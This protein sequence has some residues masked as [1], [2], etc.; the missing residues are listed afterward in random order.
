MASDQHNFPYG[1]DMKTKKVNITR[2]TSKTTTVEKCYSI[3]KSPIDDLL[4]VADDSALLGVYFSDCDHVPLEKENWSRNDRH[5]ILSKTAAELAE[6]FTGKRKDFS[7]PLRFDGT[8][9]QRK[10]WKQIAAI[11]YRETIN[12]SE[13]AKRAGKPDAIRA[14]GTTTGRNPIS[15][16]VP[17]HRVMGKNGGLCGFAG[18]LERKRF[19]L[20][21]EH[22]Q[23]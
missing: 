2:A 8:D 21:L 14:A 18:G 20:G 11:P 1:E 10:I 7:I 13:L 4:L 15:I 22:S 12:Y 3:L 9:F 19:L 5:P 17:C 6:Y 16:I 23:V